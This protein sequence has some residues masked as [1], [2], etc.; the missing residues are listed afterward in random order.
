MVVQNDMARIDPP[1]EQQN[2][3]AG[4]RGKPLRTIA[5]G[6]A[7]AVVLGL[8][9]MFIFPLIWM[10][11][12]SLKSVGETYAVPIVW[13]PERFRW[14][15]YPAALRVFPFLQYAW[16]S[17]KI[18]VP[19]TFGVTA[20]S[21]AVA[22]SFGCLR[23]RGRDTVFYLILATM[24][25]PLWITIVPLYILFDHIGWVNTF[26]PLIVP[27]FFGDAFSIFLFRQFFRRLPTA[28]FE[29]ARI[30]G[31]SHLRIF[32]QIVLPLSKP[33]IAVVAL[34]AFL[35]SWTDFFN[36][37]VYLSD[38]SR[39][40]LQLGLYDFFGRHV[41]DW[42]GFMAASF[43]VILPVIVLFLFAQRTFM[44]GITFTGLR[45]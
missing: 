13:W 10:V 38:P 42:P 14:S 19:T 29:A 35:G 33:A 34:F 28:L 9:L 12:T 20:S 27:A 30:D 5:N 25:I 31:A 16:N 1:A 37:L 6:I 43:V 41:V 8:A 26:K 2:R 15:N 45:G 32:L 11:L 22:Y 39:Y 23:W 44:Q 4:R 21:A 24:M 7:F 36:P 3:I 18:A 40:T 17:V